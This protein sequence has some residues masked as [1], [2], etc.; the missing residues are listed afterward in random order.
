MKRLLLDLDSNG[1]TDPLGM[2]PLFLKKTAEVLGPRLAVVIGGSFV[3]VAF[4]FA[5]EWLM[6]PQV[7]T[8][9]LTPQH[10]II[11]QFP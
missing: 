10:P 2:F 7:R 3:W 9:H 6:P 4:L 8:V 5:G 11:V 1:G